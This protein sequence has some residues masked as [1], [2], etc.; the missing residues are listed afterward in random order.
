MSVSILQN[1]KIL[2]VEDNAINQ[3]LVRHTLA[4]SG[5]VVQIANNGTEALAMFKANSFDIVLM[6][7]H[8]PELD[9]YQT[10]EIIRTELQ[11]SIPIV[12][13]TALAL[14]GEE[15]K[16]LAKGMNG[17][18]A[19]P[20]TTESLCNELIRVLSL[21][22]VNTGNNNILYGENVTID[23]DFL[24][25]LSSNNTGYIV[26]MLQLYLD[27]MPTYIKQLQTLIEQENYNAL[28]RQIHQIKTLLAVVMVKELQQTVTAFE[29]SVRN[30]EHKEDLL[31]LFATLSA[32]FNNSL[33]VIHKEVYKLQKDQQVA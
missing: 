6:D 4:S 30:I 9:G 1:K 32:Y 19:K 5:A 3:M 13:M 14:K 29:Q 21:Q 8:M 15:D 10:T 11:S 31:Q 25:H 20:F 7:I 18:V 26:N 24:Y 12:A 17:Y 22:Y 27:T 16:C 2:V 28:Y 23:L 33:P